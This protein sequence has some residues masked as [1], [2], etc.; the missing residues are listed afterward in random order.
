MEPEKTSVEQSLNT[1]LGMD[2]TA[3]KNT[4]PILMQGDF[5]SLSDE[6]AP[7]WVEEGIISQTAQFFFEHCRDNA[8]VTIELNDSS[9]A[10]LMHEATGNCFLA[11]TKDGNYFVRGLSHAD[12]KNLT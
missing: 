8:Q 12:A 5:T 9:E 1:S 10:Y 2:K 11:W 7:P 4:A 3:K 6:T